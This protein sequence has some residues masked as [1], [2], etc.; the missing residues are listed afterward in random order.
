MF[1]S[2]I[3]T[4]R[5]TNKH[6]AEG[7]HSFL[8]ILKATLK[9]QPLDLKKKKKQTPYCHYKFVGPRKQNFTK[10]ILQ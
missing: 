10:N 6:L 8:D 3:H 1:I 9:D 4:E 5:D 7:P 2:K